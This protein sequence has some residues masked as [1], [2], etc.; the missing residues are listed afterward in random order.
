MFR[1]Y[2]HYI[3]DKCVLYRSAASKLY[4]TNH[5]YEMLDMATSMKPYQVFTLKLGLKPEE[6][7]E[8]QMNH[9]IAAEYVHR[10]F[11]R[12]YPANK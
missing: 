5:N 11:C 12:K 4:R 7:A 1:K 3:T 10:A 9:Q 8:S 2:F 6:R